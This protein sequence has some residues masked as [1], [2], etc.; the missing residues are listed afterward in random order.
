MY[1]HTRPIIYALA[2]L[3]FLSSTHV[4][5]ASVM[6]DMMGDSSP[7]AIYFSDDGA[8]KSLTSQINAAVPA[9][10]QP[11][12]SPVIVGDVSLG[13]DPATS[14]QLQYQ[15]FLATSD[16]DFT[17]TY[18]GGEAFWKSI[19]AV[20]TYPAGQGGDP[21]SATLTIT[22]LVNQKTD[23][24]GKQVSFS[25]SA[26]SYFG[27]LV[28]ANGANTSTGRYFSENF[29]NSDNVD[30]VVTDHFQMFNTNRGLLIAVEDTAYNSGTGKLGD[31]DYNDVLFGLLTFS[32][33]TNIETPEPTTS[34]LLL[35]GG[36][37]MLGRRRRQG[38]A[39]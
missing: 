11:N 36:L 23:T 13:Q 12:G 10:T 37:V 26:G 14:N 38:N 32:D 8:A 2:V 31:S 27:F 30:G 4:A 3:V 28:N 7:D 29:R 19:L 15:R 39:A 18:L 35:I 6:P 24:K 5:Q 20:Y 21:A 9:I 16:S 1:R 34:A 22:P 17:L 25:V 33:G